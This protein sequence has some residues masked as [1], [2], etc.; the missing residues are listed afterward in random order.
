MRTKSSIEPPVKSSILDATHTERILLEVLVMVNLR[1]TGVEYPTPCF[2]IAGR[3]RTQIVAMLA[4]SVECTIYAAV[5]S[6][7]SI[8][9]AT[10]AFLQLYACLFWASIYR[11][12]KLPL[13]IIPIRQYNGYNHPELSIGNTIPIR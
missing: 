1:I 13:C 5:A 4:N 10:A 7:A 12:Q 8:E 9:V 3:S 6:E 11:N 2:A